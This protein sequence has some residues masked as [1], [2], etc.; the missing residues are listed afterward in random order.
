[1]RRISS[2]ARAKKCERLFQVGLPLFNEP[3]VRLVYKRGGLQDVP[4][5]FATKT[6]S[7]LSPQL[8][9]DQLQHLIPSVE[10]SAAPRPQ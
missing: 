7:R 3:E 10:V 9:I 2:D 5:R 1:M 4:R 8:L 6:R